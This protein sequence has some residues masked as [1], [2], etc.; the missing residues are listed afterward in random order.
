MALADR[1]VPFIF[2]YK[3][4]WRELWR[5]QRT[6]R[7]RGIVAV[8][9]LATGLQ[10]AANGLMAICAGLLGH[11]LA[12]QQFAY[13]AAAVHSQTSRYSPLLLCFLGFLAAL[14]KTGAGVLS[15]YG[16]KWASFHAGNALRQGITDII[17]HSGRTAPAAA[18]THAVI[19]IR[20]RDVERGVDEGIFAG[21]RSAA[22]I[23]PLVA[24][25]VFLSTRMAVVAIAA[26]VPFGVALG[27]LRRQLRGTY[28][29]ATRLAEN[30]HA[31]SMSSCGTSTFGEHT[32]PAAGC[33]A[34]SP[35]R[36]QRQ[37]GRQHEQM[38]QKRLSRAPT[39]RWLRPRCSLQW[40]TSSVATRH[41]SRARWWR[42]PPSSF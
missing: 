40:R 24:S 36:E 14:V 1:S 23:L 38:P 11:T 32:G 27:W 6:S 2:F 12:G 19:A 13:S 18:E 22:H 34:R 35:V 15:T 17:L 42:S 31:A 10:S 25:L 16:Q 33:N 21:A 20:L 37:H 5:D 39:R 41:W 30:L 3:W 7:S 26:L 4:V 9:V 29:Q 28:N 8:F